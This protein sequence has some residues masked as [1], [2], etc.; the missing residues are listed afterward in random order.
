LRRYS[1]EF[2]AAINSMMIADVIELIDVEF[3]ARGF[4]VGDET[5]DAGG[6]AG[7]SSRTSTRPTSNLFLLL[8]ASV[9]AVTLKVSHAPISARVE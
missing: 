5:E 6:Q 8:R 7:G 4:A 9:P 2:Y 1:V 3:I